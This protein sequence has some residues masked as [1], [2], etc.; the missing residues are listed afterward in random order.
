MESMLPPPPPESLT[1]SGASPSAPASPSLFP[2]EHPIGFAGT[3]PLKAHEQESDPFTDATKL[4]LVGSADR[5]HAQGLVDF[6]A[7]PTDAAKHIA[8]ST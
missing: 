2:E 8:V 5:V 4:E 7:V 3:P 6:M 1:L